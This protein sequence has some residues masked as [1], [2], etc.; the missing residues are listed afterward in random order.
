MN[1]VPGSGLPMM[2]SGEA[3]TLAVARETTG[4]W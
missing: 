2:W 1:V 4:I 3:S